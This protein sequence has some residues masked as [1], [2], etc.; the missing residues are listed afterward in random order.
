M[1]SWVPLSPSRSRDIHGRGA[2]PCGLTAGGTYARKHHPRRRQPCPR[3]AAIAGGCPCKGL[4]PWPTTPIGGLAM[5]GRPCGGPS[6]GQPPLS[7]LRLLQKCSK[8]A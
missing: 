3:A 1:A 2:A 4:W 7:S 6:R 8:N 5:A